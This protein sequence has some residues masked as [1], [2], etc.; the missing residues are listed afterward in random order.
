MR[1][2]TRGEKSPLVEASEVR[3]APLALRGAADVRGATGVAGTGRRGGGDGSN[4]V[5]QAG[6]TRAGGRQ[7]G[8]LYLGGR[9]NQAP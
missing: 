3:G 1:P 9:V 5:I 2:P 4:A 8:L 6:L 7:V